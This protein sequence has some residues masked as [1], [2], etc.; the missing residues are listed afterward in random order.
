LIDKLAFNPIS[1]QSICCERVFL[2]LDKQTGLLQDVSYHPS[3]NYDE[4]SDCDDISGI[5]IHNISLPPGEFGGGW[6]DDLFLNQLDPKAHP[7]FEQIHQLRVSAHLL[8][9]RTGE[10]IQYVPF[11]QRA[12]HAG[13]SNWDG[14]E[15]CN[16]F[17]IGIEL[18][19]SDDQ[20]FEITQ[21][22]KLA[23]VVST[24]FDNYPKL[25]KQRLKGHS[26]ISP[27]RKTDPGPYFDWE[28]LFNLLA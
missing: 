6:I 20:Y 13:Q 8:I 9:R 21:Y 14:R 28:K 16:D 2:K 17:T 19:G 24:L 3:P 10:V 5:V 1:V 7:Y 4:R 15:R 23:D 18:E 12:W 25:N 27:N 11:H 26:D 22:E